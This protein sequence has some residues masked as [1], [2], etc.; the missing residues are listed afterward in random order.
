MA[1]STRRGARYASDSIPYYSYRQSRAV[2]PTAGVIGDRRG[3][4]G[5]AT[6]DRHSISERGSS[7]PDPR[8]VSPQRCPS[9]DRGALAGS[10]SALT[11]VSPRRTNGVR[12]VSVRARAGNGFEPA[13]WRIPGYGV[14]SRGPIVYP[15]LHHFRFIGLCTMMTHEIQTPEI[16]WRGILNCPEANVL[17]PTEERELLMELVDCRTPH[18]RSLAAVGAFGMGHVHDRDG[19]S[20]SGSRPCELRP[21]CRS[22]RSTRSGRRRAVTRRSGASWPWPTCDWSPTSPSVTTTEASLPPIWCRKA[23]AVYFWP[24]TVSTRSTRLDSPLMPSGG[25]ARRFNERS[26]PAP[27]RFD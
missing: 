8:C 22:V 26:R 24:S 14:R 3:H 25:F 15:T 5:A 23:S 13:A 10:P 17:S 11:V 18:R 9:I 12:E 20:T 4:S 7:R 6:A 2:L 1:S 21:E 16:S 19:F 27:I